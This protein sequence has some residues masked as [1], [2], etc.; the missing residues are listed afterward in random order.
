[1]FMKNVLLMTLA[2]IPTIFR[3]IAFLA[4]GSLIII[5]KLY[6]VGIPFELIAGAV[7]IF[8][9]GSMLIKT[10]FIFGGSM[11]LIKKRR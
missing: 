11:L 10:L 9:G 3:G 6:D 1:M 7:L 4:V 8:L 5:N 2:L